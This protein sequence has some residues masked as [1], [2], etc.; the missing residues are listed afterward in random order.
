MKKAI[1][2]IR[3]KIHHIN[4]DDGLKYLNSYFE[5]PVILF[6]FEKDYDKQFLALEK[7]YQEDLSHFRFPQYEINII[8]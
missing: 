4:N 7:E 2:V 8:E 1:I 3:D 6:D 5:S